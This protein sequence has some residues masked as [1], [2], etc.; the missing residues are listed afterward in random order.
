MQFPKTDEGTRTW[1]VKERMLRE[2]ITQDAV[3]KFQKLMHEMGQNSKDPDY[4]AM[5]FLLQV[6]DDKKEDSYDFGLAEKALLVRENRLSAYRTVLGTIGFGAM[7]W[8]LFP[9]DWPGMF[10]GYDLVTPRIADFIT[11]SSFTLLAL[12]RRATGAFGTIPG[13]KRLIEIMNKPEAP[14]EFSTLKLPLFAKIMRIETKVNRARQAFRGNR[15]DL[16]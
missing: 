4:K 11:Y 14:H 5:R 7:L 13:I 3:I 2:Y 1:K 16:F 12:I 10:V 15:C 9:V 6:P 8:T